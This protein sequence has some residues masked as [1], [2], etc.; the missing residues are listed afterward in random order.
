MRLPVCSLQRSSCRCGRVDVWHTAP[1]RGSVACAAPRC[2]AAG[3]AHLRAVRRLAIALGIVLRARCSSDARRAE[4]ATKV[5]PARRVD[6][7]KPCR[8][9]CTGPERGCLRRWM[10]AVRSTAIAGATALVVQ[11]DESD[12]E[13]W[14]RNSATFRHRARQVRHRIVTRQLVGNHPQRG[15]T[16]GRILDNCGLCSVQE[17]GQEDRPVRGA[18]QPVVEP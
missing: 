13:C 12:G 4:R 2:W 11:K 15:A 8:R 9:R 5:D 14:E 6:E 17:I 1:E 16:F 10:A 3:A 7:V 18:G